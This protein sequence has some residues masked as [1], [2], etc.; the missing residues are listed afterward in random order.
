MK[1]FMN[2]ILI[3]LA[4]SVFMGS[5]ERDDSLTVLN[6]TADSGIALS[7]GTIV[8]EKANPE[9]IVLTVSWA[10]PDLGYNNTALSYQ[11][12]FDVADGDF[13]N[14]QAVSA[15]EDLSKTFTNAALNKIVLNLEVEPDAATEI[16]VK[17]QTNLSAFSNITSDAG[18]I[19]ATAYADLL[20]LSSIW[21][22]VGSATTNG[23]DGPDMPF[24]KSTAV[25][26]QFIAYV[27]L[28]D[29][30]I[31]IRSNNS[32]DV[33]YGDTGLDG[34]LEAGG[35]NIPVTAGT[36]KIVF[37]ASSL[38]YTIEAFS[39]GLVGSA[40]TNGW[41]GPDMDLTYDSFSDTW[42]AVVTL[43]DGEVK[44]RQNNQWTINY[45]DTGLD[46]ILDAGGDNIPVTAGNYLVTVDF[47]SL[48]YSI[49]PIDIWG[50]VGSAAPNGW[51]GPNVRFTPDYSTEDVWVL[52]GITLIDGEIKFRTNDSWDLNYGDTGLDGTLDAGGDNI[53]VTA[54]TYNITLDFSN[55]D[56]PVYTIE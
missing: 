25:A 54:G 47:N 41:D 56:S 34:S 43:V 10:E 24:Y 19:M 39:W 15:G 5:C 36:Y 4:I 8:L 17:V 46:G 51:D 7:T 14:A 55:P 21:G 13:S 31:K 20:D 11:V 27:K 3:L 29:G 2:K 12:L 33:N 16:L 23:W 49:E 53:P 35:D 52:N 30:E 26:D 1:A 37:N 28:T 9:D 50:L 22:L 38:T 45:G 40:T 6:P 42:K 32:W 18:S 44:V 48:E